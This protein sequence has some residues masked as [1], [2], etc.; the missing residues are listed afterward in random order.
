MALGFNI[1]EALS[2]ETELLLAFRIQ[3]TQDQPSRS[4]L[5]LLS[6]SL[7]LVSSFGA[8]S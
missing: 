6:Q 8:N 5:A 3:L 1:L 4:S 2:P 7:L